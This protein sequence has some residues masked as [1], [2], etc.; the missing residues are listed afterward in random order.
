MPDK[1]V[2]LAKVG[3]TFKCSIVEML[4]WDKKIL[5]DPAFNNYT[6]KRFNAS[7]FQENHAI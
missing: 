7:A 6:V 5:P 1:D 4:N 2:V 3:K